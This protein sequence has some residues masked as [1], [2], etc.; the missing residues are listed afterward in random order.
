MRSASI[1]RTRFAG[2]V[3]ATCCGLGLLGASSALAETKT[4]RP[5]GGSEQSFEVPAGVTHVTVS[6]IGGDGQA[7]GSCTGATGGA[8]GAG[9]LVTATVGVGERETLH[10]DFGSGG[11]GGASNPSCDGGGGAGGGASDVLDQALAPVVVAGG[12]GGGGAS[13]E[14]FQ[15]GG[16][17]SALAGESA[18]G[19]GASGSLSL[20]NS[21]GAAV[22][23]AVSRRPGK[24]ARLVSPIGANLAVKATAQAAA[25]AAGQANMRNAK[26][27]VVA[28]AATTAAVAAAAALLAVVVG[29]RLQLHRHR[30]GQRRL[31]GRH[32]QRK[33]GDHD[34]LHAP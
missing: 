33:T 31:R 7:G 29:G 25:L 26:G 21:V 14:S 30:Q 10:L 22:K 27:V 1:G 12:G 8:G 17:G 32:R 4:F 9:A 18:G 2:V 13:Y 34:L 24:A 6:A 20:L 11:N 16:G 3:V 15:G 5:E 23:A 28:A 19:N